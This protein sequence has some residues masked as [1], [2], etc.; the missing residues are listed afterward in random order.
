MEHSQQ[1]G[2]DLDMGKQTTLETRSL[3]NLLNRA[4]LLSSASNS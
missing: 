1:L 3:Q 2:T 4:R